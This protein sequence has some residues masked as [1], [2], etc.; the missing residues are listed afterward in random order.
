[1]EM[2]CYLGIALANLVNIINPELIIVGGM[3]AQGQ[4]LIL[5]TAEEKMRELAFA[6]LGDKVKIIP[7]QFGWQAGVIGAASLALNTFFYQPN[8]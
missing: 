6:G 8:E 7:T 5:P 4:D 2:A 1:M 3:F